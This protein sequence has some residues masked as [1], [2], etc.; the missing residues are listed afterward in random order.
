M[1]RQRP[2][3][4]KQKAAVA[5]LVSMEETL[6]REGCLQDLLLGPTL[7]APATAAAAGRDVRHTARGRENEGRRS[8][9]MSS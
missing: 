2:I 9:A 7:A 5:E 3:K 8:R 6:A 4:S 1:K